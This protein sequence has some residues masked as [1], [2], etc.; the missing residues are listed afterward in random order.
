MTTTRRPPGR[1]KGYRK[2]NPRKGQIAVRLDE[3]TETAFRARCEAM[4]MSVSDVLR[5]LVEG[6]LL[7]G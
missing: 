7:K 2:P 1:P 3:A 6:W 4:G 5:I